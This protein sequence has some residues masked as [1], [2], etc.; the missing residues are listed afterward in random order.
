MAKADPDCIPHTRGDGPITSQLKTSATKYSPHA[1]GW[2]EVQTYVDQDGS[3]FPTRVGMVR[4]R[5]RSRPVPLG[6]PHTRG[7]GPPWAWRATPLA[8]YSPHAWGWSDSRLCH[9]RRAAV[10]PTRV[11]MV[12]YTYSARVVIQSIPHT[13]GDGPARRHRGAVSREYSPHA[14][15]W[16]ALPAG[17]PGGQGVFPTRVGMVRPGNRGAEKTPGIP[18]TRGDGPCTGAPTG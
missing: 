12:R 9:D 4:G 14:W 7:D 8:P 16:S 5:S 1:W 10:F 6:I 13:R 11:G 3:V 17:P 15:G 18:H 2:S